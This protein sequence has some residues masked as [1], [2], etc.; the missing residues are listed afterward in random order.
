MM[1][2]ASSPKVSDPA[3]PPMILHKSYITRANLRGHGHPSSKAFQRRSIQPAYFSSL[4]L[5]RKAPNN[6]GLHSFGPRTFEH[7][8]HGCAPCLR[9]FP[10]HPNPL[11]HNAAGGLFVPKNLQQRRGG[12][13]AERPSDLCI[14]D[15]MPFRPG[16]IGN[17]G[18]P[19][20]KPRRNDE[21]P[22]DE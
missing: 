6:L 14:N 17:I 16:R 13:G 4:K 22:N 2:C 7:R 1:K 11:P 8:R 10:P 12:E 15:R 5:A 9:T 19:S 20:Y 18:N 21:I 3:T